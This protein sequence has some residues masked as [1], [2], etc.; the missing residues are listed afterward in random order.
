MTSSDKSDDREVNLVTIAKV[1]WAKRRRLTVLPLV[2][3]IC[4]VLVVKQWI[5]PLYTATSTFSFENAE[6]SPFGNLEALSG[7][8]GGGY[9]FGGGSKENTIAQIS[10]RDFLRDFFLTEGLDQDPEFMLELDPGNNTG[11]VLERAL[12]S[13]EEDSIAISE[14]SDGVLSVSI[15]SQDPQK[16]A[17]LTN[18]LVEK[19]LAFKIEQRIELSRK[20]LAYLSDEL[21]K[22][23][24][25]M[26]VANAE[27]EVFAIQANILSEGDFI[28]QTVLLDNIRER[29]VTSKDQLVLIDVLIARI[30]ED[31]NPQSVR[32]SIPNEIRDVLQLELSNTSASATELRSLFQSRYN[33]L[34]QETRNLESSLTLATQNAEATARDAAEFRRLKQRASIEEVTFD[35]FVRQFREQSVVKG[36]EGSIGTVYETAVAPIAKSYPSGALAAV[37]ASIMTGVMLAAWVLLGEAVRPKIWS[38]ADLERRPGAGKGLILDT[39]NPYDRKA[40]ASKMQ[41]VRLIAASLLEGRRT[42]ASTGLLFIPFGVSQH[43][44]ETALRQIGEEISLLSGS[45]AIVD[46]RCRPTTPARE[47]DAVKDG[48]FAE[49]DI[50]GNL[51]YIT[52]T[53][54]LPTLSSLSADNVL[55]QELADLAKRF[56]VILAMSP[57]YDAFPYV[58]WIDGYFDFAVPVIVPGKTAR[59]FVDMYLDNTD[60]RTGPREYFLALYYKPLG[61]WSRLWEFRSRLPKAQRIKLARQDAG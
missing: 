58:N 44:V 42:K 11:V 43:L 59:E 1:L 8:A 57:P 5:T 45:A 60:G 34:E 26:E 3:G 39:A 61:S 50:G 16:S 30:N 49:D 21:A 33:N 10:G 20:Q 24:A 47:A 6:A 17:D 40:L 54:D 22:L 46:L 52:F 32:D 14:N 41:S 15:T 9:D 12:Q 37:L 51:K 25:S 28:N 7:L 23:Q 55:E 19:Y 56:K 29:I 38:A 48:W 27:V 18:R 2:A 53:G 4:A 13:F 31:S 35:A 36:Y